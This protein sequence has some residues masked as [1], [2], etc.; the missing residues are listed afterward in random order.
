VSESSLP[1]T[2]S[3][4]SRPAGFPA[5]P[6]IAPEWTLSPAHWGMVAFLVSEVSFFSTLIVTYMTFMGKDTVG[7]T[8]SEALSLPLV[9]G[10]TACLLSSSATIHRAEGMLHRGDPGGFLAW[11]GATIGLGIVFLLGTAYEWRELIVKHHLT[12][13]R[14][15]FGTTYY[16]LVGFHGLHVTAGVVVMLIV[17][18]IGLRRR[19][20]STG[21]SR[22]GVGLVAW[23]WHFVDA[24]WVAVFTVVYLIGR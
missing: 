7:P 18:G 11:W 22:S 12:L 14:N 24:V 6:P 16:T 17:L 2:S 10:T 15:L 13:G 5:P 23:Y 21:P 1:A 9:L 19:R 3:T 4:L 20:P 8:P